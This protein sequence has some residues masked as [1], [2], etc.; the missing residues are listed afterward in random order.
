MDTNPLVSILMINKNHGHFL[1]DSIESYLRQSYTHL[2]IILLDGNSSDNSQEVG[3]M[4]RQVKLYVSED[5]SGSEAFVKGLA[6]CN[7]DFILFATS[8]DLL[9][10]IDFIYHSIALLTKDEGLSCVFGN[11]LVLEPDGRTNKVLVGGKENYFGDYEKNLKNWLLHKESFHELGGVFSKNVFL[12]S[13]GH[14]NDYLGKNDEIKRDIFAQLRFGFFSKGY[15]SKYINIDAIAV[16]DHFDRVSVKHRATL[17]MHW[18]LY[19]DQIEGYRREFLKD[20]K[21]YFINRMGG[22]LE[23]L[24]KHKYILFCGLIISQILVKNLKSRVKILLKVKK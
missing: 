1:S 8:N 5:E 21:Y 2:E 13:V 18:Q 20:Y 22:D 15:K 14:L 12:N 24:G 4:Y 17:L 10:D 16:R 3:R 9:V 23:P 11:V 6:H 19:L 7:G